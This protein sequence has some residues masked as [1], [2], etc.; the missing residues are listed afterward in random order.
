M[1]TFFA[2]FFNVVFTVWFIV[3]CII[4]S[5]HC[6]IVNYIV[7]DTDCTCVDFVDIVN[8]LIS[9]H[10]IPICLISILII[11]VIYCI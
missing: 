8:G 7:N 3:L 4:T 2:F 5:C 9:N 11:F 10:I 6:L 1:S